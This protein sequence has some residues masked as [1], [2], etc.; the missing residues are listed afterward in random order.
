MKET[1]IPPAHAANLMANSGNALYGVKVIFH[2]LYLHLS[3]YSTGRLSK[4]GFS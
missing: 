4:H 3:L 2:E 1:R